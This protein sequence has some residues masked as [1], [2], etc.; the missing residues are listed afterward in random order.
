MAKAG[1][2][3]THSVTGSQITFIKTAEDTNG[4]YLEVNQIIKEN[5]SL[6]AHIHALQ[7][8]TFRV[9]SGVARYQMNNQEGILHAGEEVSFAPGVAHKNPVPIGNEDLHLS[10]RVS[11]ALDFHVILETIVK[12][13]DKGDADQEGQLKPLHRA[14]LF[15]GIQS[16]VYLSGQPI[17]LQ[18]AML[19]LLAFFGKLSGYKCGYPE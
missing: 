12:A 19:P 8:E 3:I 10:V 6:P 4:E 17:W 7:T 1:E 9:I 13:P 2:V 11:P 18:K 16:K 15:N 14:V 5:S